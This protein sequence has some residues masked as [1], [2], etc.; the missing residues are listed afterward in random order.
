[1]QSLNVTGVNNSIILNWVASLPLNILE[2]DQDI[3]YCVKVADSTSAMLDEQCGI[4]VTEF[5]YPVIACDVLTFTVT[6]FNP[7]GSGEQATEIYVLEEGMMYV[8]NLDS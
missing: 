7:V 1:M 2:L 5:T 6:P 4:T 8:V 3:T